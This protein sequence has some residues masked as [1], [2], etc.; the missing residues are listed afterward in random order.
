[1]NGS[2]LDGTMRLTVVGMI[3]VLGLLTMFFGYQAMLLLVEASFVDGVCR[4]SA[5]ALFGV[6]AYMLAR[7]RND[8]L[9]V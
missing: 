3:A 6:G 7:Y 1:M 8:L 9:D 5:S 4:A 2:V